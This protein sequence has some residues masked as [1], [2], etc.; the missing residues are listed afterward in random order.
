VCIASVDDGHIG[1]F[2]ASASDELRA[3]QSCYGRFSIWC[4]ASLLRNPE[5]IVRSAK[6]C[7]VRKLY[8]VAG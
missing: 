3:G 5:M 4:V 7:S 2:N 8:F 6:Q 1:I